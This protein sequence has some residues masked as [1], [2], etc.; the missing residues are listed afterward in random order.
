MKSLKG[1][2]AIVTG[3][4][5]SKGIGTAI[6][7]ELARSGADVFFTHYSPFDATE[8]NGFE[9]DSPDTLCTSLKSL[10]VRSSHIEV[11]LE[12][13]DSPLFL[14]DTVEEQL[15]VATI[16]VNN[17]T[18]ESP[19]DFR[20][21]DIDTL[22]KHYKVNNRGT[23]MLSL[24]FAKRFE[25]QFGP[26]EDGRIINLVSGGPDPNNLAY[27]AT[28]GFIKAITHP[29]AVGLAPLGIN[30]NSV[31]PGPTDSGWMDDETKERL[32]PLFPKGR[33]G[34]TDDAAN[35]VLFLSSPE[36]KWM[37]GQIIHSNGGYM[38]R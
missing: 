26:E 16:L 9:K 17:A 33:L 34:N 29:L 6:C 25:K 2:I 12:N 19:T 35:T 31:D 13:E 11:D 21:L 22:D 36:S 30:V 32:L 14:L 28:K 8:G 10:G 7:Y 15:G 20:S 24:E 5:R 37:T 23:L 1:K 18:F 4:S 38:G 3:A 27:I